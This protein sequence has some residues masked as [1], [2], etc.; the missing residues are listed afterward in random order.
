MERTHGGDWAAY[1][2]KYGVAPLDFSANVSPLG[3]PEGVRE[4]IC[5]AAAEIDRYP[6]PN[7]RELCVAI[8]EKEGVA[9]DWVQCGNGA[10]D[11]IWRAVLA[12][13]PKRALVTAPCF[14]EYEAAL[15]AVDC[16]IVRHPLAETFE[17]AEAILQGIDH[18]IDITIL[19]NPNNPTGRTIEPALLRRIAARCAETGTRLLLD[20]CFADFLD[21]PDRHTMRGELRKRPQLLICK[22]FTKLYGM[23]GVRLGYALSAD[24]AFLNAM[25]RAGPPWNVSTL[26]Q[27][28]GL[29][30]LQ[31]DNYVNQ[32][33]SL[34][35]TERP[36]LAAAL[37]A[38]GLRVVP[39]EANYL[40]FRSKTPLL[41][42]LR[43][44]GILLRGCGDFAGL[45]E[46]WYRAAVRTKEDNDC[47]IT[48]LK[49]VLA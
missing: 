39:G 31:D 49:E 18:N 35:R 37:S 10:S 27:A 38:L 9:P 15:E 6:D 34:I 40:L 3:V 33:Q 20:E 13:K 29:F 44:R 21:K 25:R 42:P 26:A 28:A 12:A 30:A 19:C 11:L 5:R 45:D 14:G 48:A 2:R 16:E 24:T 32:L 8:A 23:A 17:L 47:L 22:A 36:R 43:E 4:A 7:C 1:E 41:Q 46:T